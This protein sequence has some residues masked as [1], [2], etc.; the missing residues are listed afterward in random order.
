MTEITFTK[1]QTAQIIAKIK[2]YFS[3]ELNQEIGGFEAEF[4]MEFFAKEI[5]PHF[6]NSGLADAK[7]LFTQ[8]LEEAGY[9]IDELEKST[10]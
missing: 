3:T 9:M 6:Y 4:L 1:E 10:D 5:G 2:T 8:Q 7:E